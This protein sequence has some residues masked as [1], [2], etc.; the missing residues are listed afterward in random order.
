MNC[1]IDKTIDRYHARGKKM[2]V[3]KRYIRM[4]YRISIDTAVLK[5]RLEQIKPNKLKIA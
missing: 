3:I 2:E 1:L 4:K 5:A